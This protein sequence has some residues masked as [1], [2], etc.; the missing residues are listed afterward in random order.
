MADDI[1]D[2]HD[3]T[4]HDHA[5]VQRAEREKVCGNFV[6]VQADGGEQQGERNR[7]CHNER[8]AHVAQKKE[9]DDGDE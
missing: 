4:V 3:R 9:Q 2:D 5:E 1:F 6:Q 7:Q 8:A